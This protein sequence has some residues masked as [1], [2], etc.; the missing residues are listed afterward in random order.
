MS[1]IS[2]I[3]SD[4][5]SSL[6]TQATRSRTDPAEK[7]K[8]LDTDGNSNLDTTELS[9]LAQKLS[10]MT[11]NTLSA[12]DAITT[13]DTD[14]DGELSQNEMDNMIKNVLEPPPNSGSDF[15]A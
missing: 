8:E 2:G 9:P 7:F 11:G 15:A 4:I 14:G 5:L 12:E 10:K 13:Y 3:S 6:V 1:G